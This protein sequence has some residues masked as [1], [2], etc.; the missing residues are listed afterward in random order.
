MTSLL[1]KAL[2]TAGRILE[3]SNPLVRV[4]DRIATHLLPATTAKA[5]GG[6]YCGQDMCVVHGNGCPHFA[7]YSLYD[8]IPGDG[9]AH[10]AWCF[11]FCSIGC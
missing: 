9:C 5:C 3:H 4:V 6:T 1:D 10:T 11:D 8:P 7:I 2:T